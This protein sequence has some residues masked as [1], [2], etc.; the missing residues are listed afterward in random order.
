MLLASTGASALE[1]LSIAGGALTAVITAAGLTL[2]IRPALRRRVH[3]MDRLDQLL[4]D[5]TANP[6]I[7]G[8]IELVAALRDEVADVRDNQETVRALAAELVPNS[9]SSFRDAYNRDQTH[10]N[11]VNEAIGRALGVT[12]PDP[13]PRVVRHHDDDGE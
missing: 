7:P 13:P 12:L 2:K 3:R 9:G 8:V 5:P 10:Q 1:T 6:P 4:G 11:L